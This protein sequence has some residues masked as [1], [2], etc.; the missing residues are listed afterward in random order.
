[1]SGKEQI[2]EE[3]RDKIQNWLMNEGWQIAE[4][5]H[6]D[7]EWLIRAED[8]GGRRILVGQ[9]KAKSDQIHLEARVDLADEHHKLFE[10]LP[11]D[12]RRE[13]LWRLRFRLL[14]MNV[15]FVGVAEPMQ[16]VLLTQRIYL[17]GLTKDAFLQRF[18][19]VRNAVITV[20]WSIIQY[21]EDVE[22]PAESAEPKNKKRSEKGKQSKRKKQA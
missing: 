6:P 18:L 12:K 4:Q 1:M 2:M 13:T 10:T 3:T 14:A 21:L 22:P 7:F 5:T 17:D 16:S 9:N 19:I 11:A 15:D 20:I 8:A